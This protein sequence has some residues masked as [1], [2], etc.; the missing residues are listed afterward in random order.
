MIVVVSVRLEGWPIF[1]LTGDRNF[2][3]LRQE[4]FRENEACH[5]FQPDGWPADGLRSPV[6]APRGI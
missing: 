2:E 1:L 4:V 3:E 6:R 5:V